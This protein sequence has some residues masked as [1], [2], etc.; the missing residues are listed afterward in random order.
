MEADGV[1]GGQLTKPGEQIVVTPAE[2]R[3][4]L[5]RDRDPSA[6]S[7]RSAGLENVRFERATHRCTGFRALGSTRSSTVSE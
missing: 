5:R 4:E 6:G 7:E 2:H 1:G 3:P